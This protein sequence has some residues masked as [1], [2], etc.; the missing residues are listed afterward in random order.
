M[1][2]AAERPCLLAWRLGER[3]EVGSAASGSHGRG[4]SMGVAE[5]VTLEGSLLGQVQPVPSE[6]TQALCIFLR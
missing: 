6:L 5:P 2:P 4:L 1:E 3:Q